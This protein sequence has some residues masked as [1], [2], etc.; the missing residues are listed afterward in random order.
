MNNDFNEII[1]NYFTA[2]EW[3]AWTKGE[4]NLFDAFAERTGMTKEDADRLRAKL[5]PLPPPVVVR[6]TLT[7]EEVRD[8][9]NNNERNNT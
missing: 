5:N 4:F 9:L 2:E 3:E 8:I 7:K 1:G 6:K